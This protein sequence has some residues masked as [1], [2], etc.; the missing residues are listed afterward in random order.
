MSATLRR[1]GRTLRTE[2]RT[3]VLMALVVVFGLGVGSYLVVHERLQWPSWFPFVGKTYYNLNAQVTAVS[4]VLP[5]QGQAVTVSGVT[6]GQISGVSLSNGVPVVSMKIDPQ[7][8]NRIY[9]NATVL[10]RPKTG[11]EDMVAELDPGSPRGAHLLHSGATIQRGNTAPTIQFDQIIAELDSDTRA[12]LMQLIAGAGQAVSGKG[13][14]ELGNVLRDFDPLTRNVKVASEL[15]SLRSAELTRLMGNLSKIATALGDNEHQLTRFVKGNAG[16][17]HAFAAE[18]QQLQETIRLL[19]GALGSTDTALGDATKL[20]H[21]LHST[22]T[23]LGPSAASLGTTLAD[24]Q[25][26]FKQTTPVIANQLRPFSEK[27]QPTA[28]VLGPATE[29][30]AK[31]TPG[32]TRLATELNNIL[33]ELAYKSKNSQ[34]YLFYVPWAN[35]DTNSALSSQDGVSPLQQNLL[36]YTCGTLQFMQNFIKDPAQNPTLSTLINLLNLPNYKRVC[37]ADVPKR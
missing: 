20:G 6:V 21:T 16:V 22:F 26:F 34:S 4:G 23:N 30:L 31:S 37:S 15:V 9:S 8:A 11:L 18:D 17:W 1:A 24:L 33:N 27:A 7:Y 5:G 13:G 3:V 25:P 29:K 35:H 10:L 12:E 14:T 2:L 19:P 28:R 32:L 36:L